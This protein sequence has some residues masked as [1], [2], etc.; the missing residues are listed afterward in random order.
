MLQR[1]AQ[2]LLAAQPL[3]LQQ[4]CAAAAVAASSSSA[5]YSSLP[6][7]YSLVFDDRTKELG[8]HVPTPEREIGMCT[9]APL[10]TYTRKVGSWVCL[11]ARGQQLSAHVLMPVPVQDAAEYSAAARVLASSQ[12]A[13]APAATTADPPVC[14]CRHTP[15]THTRNLHPSTGARLLPS[16]HSGAAGPGQH[17]RQPQGPVVEDCL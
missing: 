5:S 1:A 2:R 3:S 15:R 14:C 10:E 12:V 4:S 6:G 17:S 7:D 9:G 13:L 11:C 8:S 16:A